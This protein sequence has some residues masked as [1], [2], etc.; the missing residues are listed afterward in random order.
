MEE[1]G[2]AIADAQQTRRVARR[3]EGHRVRET[4]PHI[5]HAEHVDEELAELMDARRDRRDAVESP[6]VRSATTR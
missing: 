2:R 3:M 1:P 5:G 4:R 6:D